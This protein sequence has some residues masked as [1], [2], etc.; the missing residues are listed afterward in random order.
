MEEY[1]LSVCQL[2]LC[3][4]RHYSTLH[5]YNIRGTKHYYIAPLG[6]GPSWPT[7]SHLK[8][9]I[10]AEYTKQSCVEATSKVLNNLNSL[11]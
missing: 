6:L 9:S 10:S 2:N 7:Y 5:Y 8:V 11:D 1:S 4:S 3:H